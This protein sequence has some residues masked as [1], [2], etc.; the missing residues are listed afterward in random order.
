MTKLEIGSLSF[1]LAGVYALVQAFPM[2][3]VFGLLLTEFGRTPVAEANPS[4]GI[5]V[6]VEIIPF[7][8]L[9]IVGVLLMRYSSPLAH[10]VFHEPEAL[11]GTRL[12]AADLRAI[13]VS[14]IGIAMIASALPRFTRFAFYLS[15]RS[16]SVR[17]MF[18]L[19]GDLGPELVERTAQLLIGL[20]LFFGAKGVSDFRRKVRAIWLT[21]RGREER[22]AEEA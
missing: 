22:D 1:K 14:V 3:Q 6:A 9:I 8:L 18:V 20:A 15:A 10:A 4:W 16:D 13:A 17:S 21:L 19:T 12:S 11:A 5:L 2:L 7:L